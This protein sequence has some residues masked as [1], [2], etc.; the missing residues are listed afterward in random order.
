MKE[1]GADNN[2]QGSDMII[3]LADESDERPLYISTWGGANTL[4]QA[5][6]KVQ[7]TRTKEQLDAIKSIDP[8]GDKLP[9]KWWQM[10]ESGTYHKELNIKDKNS[11][12]VYINISADASKHEIHIIS[13]VSDN[14]KPN[15]TS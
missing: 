15:L 4:A 13:E 2:T 8:D 7:Q 9:V 6:L 11:E 14:G 12:C 3:R 10:T 5:I 1:I